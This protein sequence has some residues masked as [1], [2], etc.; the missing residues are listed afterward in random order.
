MRK[1]PYKHFIWLLLVLA[2]AGC[3][4]EKSV[5]Q[6]DN[7][8]TVANPSSEPSEELVLYGSEPTEPLDLSEGAGRAAVPFEEAI[9]E[10]MDHRREA[11]ETEDYDLYMGAITKNNPYLFYEAGKKP[12]HDSTLNDA[13]KINNQITTGEVIQ[14]VLGV[15]KAELSEG[16]LAWLEHQEL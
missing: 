1:K 10:I 16:Y 13:F 11:I 8:T 2:M 7:E 5:I 4:Q 15:T 6:P 3:A 14:S 9:V 12:F